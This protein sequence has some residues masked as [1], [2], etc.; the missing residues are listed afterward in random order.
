MSKPAPSP[1]SNWLAPTK[2]GFIASARR[3]ADSIGWDVNE[4]AQQMYGRN[5]DQLNVEQGF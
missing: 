3:A 1:T 5:I 4:L 2:P